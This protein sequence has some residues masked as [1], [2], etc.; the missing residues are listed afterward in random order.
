MDKKSL[1]IVS[2]IVIVLA[3]VLGIARAYIQPS[4]RYTPHRDENNAYTEYLKKNNINQKE[5][6]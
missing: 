1:V 5:N 2:I 6:K 3:C 4:P